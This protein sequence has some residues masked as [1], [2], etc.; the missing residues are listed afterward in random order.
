MRKWVNWSFCFI[1]LSWG[2]VSAPLQAE[3]L[4]FHNSNLLITI[5]QDGSYA[6][7]LMAGGQLILRSTVAA[8]INYRWLKS[9][10]F[11]RHV[12]SKSHFQDRLGG[13]QLVAIRSTGLSQHPDLIC[14][15]RLYSE[16]SF[17]TVE[18]K[19][20]NRTTRSI[21]VQALRSVDAVGDSKLNLNGPERK[22]RVMSDTEDVLRV[23]DLEN[24]PSG[25]HLGFG[26]QLIYNTES[27][28]SAF[29]G[30]LTADRFV[31][32]IR[33]SA[34][35]NSSDPHIN[36]LTVESIGTTQMLRYLDSYIK[37]LP[38]EEQYE[39]NVHLAPGKALSSELL[40]VAA[41]S[42]YYAQLD[43]YGMAVRQLHH[44]RV[45]TE[46]M[47]GWA[48]HKIYD[49]A[50]TEDYILANA[51]WLAQRLAQEG[52]KYIH[53]GPGTARARG[54]IHPDPAKF[55]HGMSALFQKISQVGLNVTG[56][57][58]LLAVD[59]TSF[60]Y[61]QHRDWLVKNARGQPLW[62][63]RKH[64]GGPPLNGYSL[65]T[66][67]P[68]V[69]KYLRRIFRTM[70]HEWGWRQIDLDGIFAWAVEGYRHRR[71]TTALEAYRIGLQIIRE[72]VGNDVR[73]SLN[74]GLL[75]SSVGFVDTALTSD[76]RFHTF[77]STKRAGPGIAGHYYMHRNFFAND[78]DAF[79]VQREVPVMDVREGA[80][81]GPL[82][83]ESAQA[84]IVL[85]AL[86]P[87][88]RFAIGDDLP[89]LG[90]EPERLA[91]VTN[92][93]LLQMVKLG[94]SARP[95]DLMTYLPEDEQPSIF[96][97]REDPRQSMLAVFNW[98]ERPRSHIFHPAELG[99]PPGHEYHVYDVLN[100]NRPI[101][102]EKEAIRLDNQDSQ[103][104]KLIKII[105]ESIPAAAP[106]ITA[107]A[108]E[109]AKIQQ[110]IRFSAQAAADGVP[111]IASRWEFGD[112]TMAEGA[113]QF[114]TY[115]RPGTYTVKL[116]VDGMDGIAVERRFQIIV[117]GFME[118]TPPH[119]GFYSCC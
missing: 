27:K 73:L 84:S 94:R 11:P 14:S 35:S 51:R 93:D 72:T 9:S 92:P 15:I 4:S 41:G 79:C 105:D 50:I 100:D 22:I 88:A 87:G 53:L 31:T 36:R 113:T 70:V 103:S 55:P 75:L 58:D 64:P 32:T 104:V 24:A 46:T 63:I 60:I 67:H 48:S 117:D 106:T 20:E 112:G 54:D 23:L 82:R 26:S 118:I 1:L 102:L 47:L 108:P 109:H 6:V 34:G 49:D 57:M 12:L 77:F 25:I 90:M 83:L 99:L 80:V 21:S 68:E 42:D 56:F 43:T 89:N 98:T 52:F 10:S 66:T 107:E 91:L 13:G 7:Q 78:P 74:G 37:Y 30:A 69:Q 28:Q 62:L 119:Q 115:T 76:D 85:S 97:L 2:G 86:V 18:L 61:K 16:L 45:S 44:A 19:V 8:R 114:H 38:A 116:M 29:L 71:N 17:A 96:F 111:A 65:D 101:T 40:M 95:L 81:P 3:D 39:A 110:N 59:E 5:R 33:L